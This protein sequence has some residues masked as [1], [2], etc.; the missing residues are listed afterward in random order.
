MH[1]KTFL[2][3]NLGWSLLLGFPITGLAQAV[4]A[5]GRTGNCPVLANNKDFNEVKDGRG[6]PK[7]TA[8]PYILLLPKDSTRQIEMSTKE[9]ITEFR[10]ENPRV[11][12]V[13]ALL[14][15]PRA[16]WS[17]ACRRA[18]PGSIITDSKK[19]T[20]SLEVRVP[21]DEEADREAKRRELLD[22][23]QKVGSHRGGGCRGV[24]K[25]DRHL[26]RQRTPRRQ[27]AGGH[28]MARGVFGP[29]ANIVNHMRIGACSRCKSKSPWP[30]SIARGLVTSGLVSSTPAST[31]SWP[32]P[33]AAA[34]P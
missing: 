15:N 14:D 27:R 10:S 25:R 22:Q 20:E 13:Q 26:D 7:E 29:A 9:L 5:Q 24:R 28:G 12:K 30:A 1:R 17:P 18:A 6:G 31:I 8:E 23:I 16:V 3:R 4:S 33:S 32:A 21:L 19:N 2:P 34:A 11:V